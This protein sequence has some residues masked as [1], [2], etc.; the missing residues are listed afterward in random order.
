MRTGDLKQVDLDVQNGTF[1][2]GTFTI[3]GE[4]VRKARAVTIKMRTGDVNQV[5]IEVIATERVKVSTQAEVHIHE[6]CAM[7]GQ[8]VPTKK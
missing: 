5:D 4:P 1:I 7:C 6:M 2:G 8:E 3:D